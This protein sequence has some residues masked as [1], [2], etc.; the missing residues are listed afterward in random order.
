[1]RAGGGGRYGVEIEHHPKGRSY[2]GP[3]IF[4]GPGLLPIWRYS[5]GE[6]SCSHRCQ[7]LHR[8][9]KPLFGADQELTH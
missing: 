7:P 6:T 2:D 5:L 3:D 8:R 4:G 1:M 9:P